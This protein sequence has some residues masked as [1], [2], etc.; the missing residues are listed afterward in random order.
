MN[1]LLLAGEQGTR[2]RKKATSLPLDT[3]RRLQ[4]I[5][6]VGE[7][8]IGK[9][10]L[11]EELSQGAL[12]RGWAVAWSRVYAQESSVPYRQW[13]E[14]LRSAMAHG[15]WQQQEISKH[16]LTYQPLSTLLPEL[17]DLFPGVEFPT[18]LSPEQEQ[19]RLWETTLKLLY[20]ISERTPLLLVLDDFH[21]VGESE[22]VGNAIDA[23]I[24]DL[25][26]AGQI[27]I[28]GSLIGMNWLTGRHD[29]EG[30]IDG[31]GDVP[32]KLAAA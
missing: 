8:G 13:T 16:P 18:P 11:A 14:V 25:P 6:L 26:D 19:L 31:L 15:L 24:R 2:T 22:D 30:S 12:K 3:Q 4:C 1:Q 7:A 5:L 21:A 27:V 28:T 17:H 20:A 23:L 9:T 10:R 29:L 32:I